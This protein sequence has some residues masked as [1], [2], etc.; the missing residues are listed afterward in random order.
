MTATTYS[1]H[2]SFVFNKD[3]CMLEAIFILFR[4]KKKKK[5]SKKNPYLPAAFHS[6]DGIM[7]AHKPSKID[8]Y[9][10]CLLGATHPGCSITGSV[11]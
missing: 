2:T 4:L 10:R 3:Y 5:T 1:V 8:G 9:N 6:C 11:V 7:S